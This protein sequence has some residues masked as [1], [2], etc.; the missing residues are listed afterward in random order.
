M[1]CF[2]LLECVVYL[3]LEQL[4]FIIFLSIIYHLLLVWIFFEIYK[5][6]GCIQEQ[7]NNDLSPHTCIILVCGFE[8]FINGK[9]IIGSVKEKEQARK[10]YKEAISK[11]H[12]A[13][14]ME[15]QEEQAVRFL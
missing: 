9:H 6:T 2:C 4:I 12:G 13:Y 1:S 7:T 5:Y 8:A 10:E 3:V 15:E 14:L 11:G